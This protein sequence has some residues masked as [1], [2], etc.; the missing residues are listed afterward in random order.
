MG[1]A[2]LCHLLNVLLFTDPAGAEESRVLVPPVLLEASGTLTEADRIG[3]RTTLERYSRALETKDLALFRRAKPNL[4]GDEQQRLQNSFKAI[5]TLR[6]RMHVAG[7]EARGRGAA[8][9]VTRQDSVNG[10]PSHV[11]QQTFVLSQRD[12]GWVISSIGK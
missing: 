4:V 9:R 3:I 6:I 10:M 12:G 7:I 11:V 8:V 5:R 1:R 2:A